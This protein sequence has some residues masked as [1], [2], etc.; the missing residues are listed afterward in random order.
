MEGVVDIIVAFCMIFIVAQVKISTLLCMSV[1]V[2]VCP[3]MRMYNARTIAKAR[4]EAPRTT[5]KYMVS[6]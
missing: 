1:C 3:V 2:C 6:A 5:G 4:A